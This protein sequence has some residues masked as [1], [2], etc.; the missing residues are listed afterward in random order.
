MPDK[1]QNSTA[2]ADLAAERARRGPKICSQCGFFNN[3]SENGSAPD[4]WYNHRC[5]APPVQAPE[6][7]NPQTG[8]RGYFRLNDL[9]G[10]YWDDDSR[11]YCRDINPAGACRYFRIG[12]AGAT[13]LEK[14]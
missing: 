13:V 12:S 10:G 8:E 7:I 5:A 11:P 9:G 2:V 14:I 3:T 6:G 1:S 4:I